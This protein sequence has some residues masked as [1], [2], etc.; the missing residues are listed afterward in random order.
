MIDHFA[1]PWVL[2]LLSGLPMLF[3]WRRRRTPAS[4]VTFSSVV[5]A[6]RLN[7]SMRSRV[8]YLP[9][10]LRC[11]AL[12]ALLIAVSR[13]Q[14]TKGEVKT[15]TQGVAIQIVID[16]SG[17][18]QESID[19]EEDPRAARGTDRTKFETVKRVIRDF[20]AGDGKDLKGRPHDMI[21]VIAFARYADTV[22]PL[23]RVHAPLVEGVTNLQTAVERT[24]EDG[25]AIGDGLGLACARLKRAEEE[26]ARAIPKDGRS[27]D[28]TIKSKVVV[29][30]TDG[31]NNAGETTPYE[32][33]ELAKKWGIRVYT[34]GVGP[35]QRFMPGVFGDRVA[36]GSGIDEEMLRSIAES[37]GGAWWAAED[38]SSLREAYKA[39]DVLEKSRIDSTEHAQREE[40]YMPFALAGLACLMAESLLASTLLRRSP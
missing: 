28:F 35:R 30:L 12:G 6:S 36:V 10:V 13:P 17:S 19:P 33:A 26:V 20:V 18:M 14:S 8:R 34:I 23:T 15:S 32:A 27:P 5:I 38:A 21:G 3:W 16:R 9:D 37:T 4:A 39:I 31:Q 40:R 24:P 1:M 2:I 22:S 7:P 25:T 11:F 29:L